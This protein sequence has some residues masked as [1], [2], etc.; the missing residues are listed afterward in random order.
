MGS[1]RRAGKRGGGGVVVQRWLVADYTVATDT[2]CNANYIIF[3]SR[4][5][6]SLRHELVSSQSYYTLSAASIIYSGRPYGVA[7]ATFNC[8]VKTSFEVSIS[9]PSIS[10]SVQ[11]NT[12]PM[13]PYSSHVFTIPQ[14]VNGT[15]WL[16]VKSLKGLKADSSTQLMWRY[17]MSFIK[18]QTPKTLYRPGQLMQFTVF[19]HNETMQAV[20]PHTSAVIWI[21]D[22]KGNR[23]R[24]YRNFTVIKGIFQSELHLSRQPNLG[25]WRICSKNGIYSAEECINI[26]V[27]HYELPPFE[28]SI[29]AP[30]E[31]KSTEK[32]FEVKIEAKYGINR[33]IDGNLTL[34]IRTLA[35]SDTAHKPVLLRRSATLINGQVSILLPVS[36]FTSSIPF[37]MSL[38]IRLRVLVQEK[39]TDK[40]ETRT[41]VVTLRG[42]SKESLKNPHINVVMLQPAPAKR[43]NFTKAGWT[44]WKT[45]VPDT[46][47]NWRLSAFSVNSA[48]GLTLLSPEPFIDIKSSKLVFM[49]IELPYSIKVG[50]VLKLFLICSNQ[51]DTEIDVEIKLNQDVKR[52]QLLKNDGTPLPASDFAK[53]NMKIMS[54]RTN[55]V[56]FNLHALKAGTLNLTFNAT[57]DIEW[58][59]L[60]REVVVLNSPQL[61]TSQVV[62]Y[63]KLTMGNPK[64]KFKLHLP[65]QPS[66]DGVKCFVSSHVISSKLHNLNLVKLSDNGE[67]LIS[68]LMSIYNLWNYV[69]DKKWLSNRYKKFLEDQL[70]DGFQSLMRLRTRNGGFRYNAAKSESIC[71]STWL[72]TFALQLIQLLR[73][74][75][76]NFDHSVERQAE[77]FLINRIVSAGHFEERCETPGRRNIE[78]LELNIEVLKVLQYS[79]RI[80]P[81][82]GPQKWTNDQMNAEKDYH[83]LAKRGLDAIEWK[84]PE[85]HSKVS[86]MEQRRNLE[87]AGRI[88]SRNM[89]RVHVEQQR[90]IF[91]WLT[92]QLFEVEKNVE[93]YE[94]SVA[95]QA[96][97]EYLQNDVTN[98]SRL[99]VSMWGKKNKQN[100]TQISINDKNLW[101][102]QEVLIATQ[103][104]IIY[105]KAEGIGQLLIRCTYQY[106]PKE[107]HAP[108]KRYQISVQTSTGNLLNITFCVTRNHFNLGDYVGS[109][110]ELHLPSGHILDNKSVQKLLS[111]QKVHQANE[112]DEQTK[113]FVNLVGLKPGE[114][115]CMSVLARNYHKLKHLKPAMVY[116]SDMN[117]MKTSEAFAFKVTFS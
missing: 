82:Q 44:N 92:V 96:F 52:Y 14:L 17:F 53:Q 69:N 32:S 45:R 109:N 62:F 12:S 116:A 31:V 68:K 34:Y 15:Y 61:S 26:R 23:V 33:P 103:T 54:H 117:D 56:T 20:I 37:R 19:Y 95:K 89:G 41:K 35:E 25:N 5:Q 80:L 98:I 100:K 49:S 99:T 60:S 48:V 108:K 63:Q 51:H 28:V 111:T 27:N 40:Q 85:N 71:S 72:T 6:F 46:I 8:N 55:A 24:V 79:K 102:Q 50:E 106:A 113:L 87:T 94:C 21:E 4:D 16:R 81:L 67:E 47:T 13:H 74:T 57:S 1:G 18:L 38:Q 105:I 114:S 107:V 65:Y 30:V 86:W 70:S 75:P 36:N 78:T 91:N 73:N 66:D 77:K 10:V 58:D 84:R 97:Y 88:L 43:V 59:I 11:L 29:D 112:F 83:L 101:L 2:K 39:F 42:N 90:E 93:C 104:P 76:I 110:I 9:G 64:T 3:I 7:L 115:S 22:S